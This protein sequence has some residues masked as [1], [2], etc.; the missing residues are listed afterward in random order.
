M[1]WWQI[2]RGRDSWMALA[3]RPRIRSRLAM[4][5]LSSSPSCSA[6]HGGRRES[7]EMRGVGFE[8]GLTIGS[9]GASS[10]D[11]LTCP[12]TQ[13]RTHAQQ[14]RAWSEKMAETVQSSIRA[15]TQSQNGRRPPPH[16]I[17]SAGSG[18]KLPGGWKG[19]NWVNAIP[20]CPLPA[21]GPE[22]GAPQ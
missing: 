10:W 8:R 11:T 17:T 2:S 21:G 14:H 20:F 19:G 5:R 4:R 16:R 1:G 12:A 3:K 13:S 6:R 7:V 22:V 18:Q 9:V 15:S